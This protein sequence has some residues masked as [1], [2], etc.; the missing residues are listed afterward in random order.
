MVKSIH[1][2]VKSIDFTA[3]VYIL[4]QKNVEKVSTFSVV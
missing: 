4:R 3:K 2:A 1:F